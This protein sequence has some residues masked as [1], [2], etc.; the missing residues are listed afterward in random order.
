MNSYFTLTSFDTD[1]S[2]PAM[3][4]MNQPI[5]RVGI[6]RLNKTHILKSYDY[7]FQNNFNSSQSQWRFTSPESDFQ[8]HCPQFSQHSFPNS[9]SYPPFPEPYIEE[10]SSLERTLEE[11]IE[12]QKQFENNMASSCPQNFQNSYSF[13]PE[14][15]KGKS[16]WEKTMEFVQETERKCKI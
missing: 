9:A 1:N 8:P 14:Q 13:F 16:L 6:I 11:V 7:N 4:N 2:N 5:C 3:Y 12:A 15:L 10:K